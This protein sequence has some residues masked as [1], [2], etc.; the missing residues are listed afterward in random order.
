MRDLDK[1]LR[2]VNRPLWEEMSNSSE[3]EVLKEDIFYKLH[4][5]FSFTM[6]TMFHLAYVLCHLHNLNSK[7]ISSSGLLF[8]L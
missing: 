3:K 7:R 6:M 2:I 8:A 4:F 1:P 5:V